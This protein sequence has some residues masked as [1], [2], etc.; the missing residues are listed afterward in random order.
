MVNQT[1]SL[2]SFNDVVNTVD[3]TNDKYELKLR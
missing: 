1:T 2:P 3:K